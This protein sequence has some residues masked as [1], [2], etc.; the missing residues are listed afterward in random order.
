M[1]SNHEA[2]NQEE[3]NHEAIKRH[4]TIARQTREYGW[5][6]YREG[7]T[8]KRIKAIVRHD[9][10]CRNGHNS[11]SITGTTE[12]YSRGE[13]R[14]CQGG[15]IH[16]EIKKHFPELAHLIKWH[17]CSTDGPWGYIGN[18]LYHANDKD[19]N[20]LRKGEFRQFRNKDGSLAW[21]LKDLP[22]ELKHIDANECPK[23]LV[24]EYEAWGTQGEGKEID[25]EAARRSALWPEATLSDLQSKEALEARLPGLMAEFRAAVE[26][27][28]LTY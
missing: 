20:G 16:K 14:D 25:I 24:I 19:H 1:N 23:P 15:C 11:F 5:K 4:P 17:L 10:S 3:T 6:E 7:S 8:K 21:I 22:P 18:T 26:S 9:D 2:T 12:Y 27:L 28:G 13:W